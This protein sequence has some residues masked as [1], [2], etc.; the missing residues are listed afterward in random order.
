[1]NTRDLEYFLSLTELKNFTAV[2]KRFGVSQPTITTAVK[3]LEE[4]YQT[5]LI[6]RTTNQKEMEVTRAGEILSNRAKE[7]LQTL[8]VTETELEHLQHANIRFGLPPII[9][10][11]YFSQVS[12]QLLEEGLLPHL[13]TTETGSNLLLPALKRGE[14]DVALLA[15]LHPLH[16]DQVKSLQLASRPFNLIV[17]PENPLANRQTVSFKELQA[18]NFISLTGRYIHPQALKAY[19][20]FSGITPHIIYSTPDYAILKALIAQNLGVGLL[21]GDAVTPDDHLVK[22]TLTDEVAVKFNIALATRKG[23]VTTPMEQELIDTLSHIKELY[24]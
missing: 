13:K 19:S 2:S 18:E 10:N 24:Q 5:K 4:H 14:I 15:S 22:L 16:D 1:M 21:V 6:N 23:Y 7:V 11:L 12:G 20:D 9:G 3:R 17:S 8:R